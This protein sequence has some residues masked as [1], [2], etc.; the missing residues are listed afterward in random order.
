MPD[1]PVKTAWLQSVR[2]EFKTLVDNN[3][4]ILDSPK[5]RRERNPHNGN[6]QG[7]NSE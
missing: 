4:F 7:E 5:K 3:T 1:G 6:I 2:K